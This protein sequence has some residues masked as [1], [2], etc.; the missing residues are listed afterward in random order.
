M[1]VE[2]RAGVG[3]WAGLGVTL[4]DEGLLVSLCW[5]PRTL[6]CRSPGCLWGVRKAPLRS[7]VGWGEGLAENLETGVRGVEKEEED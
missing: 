6:Q 3:G 2:S 5:G 4:M 1:S 7:I